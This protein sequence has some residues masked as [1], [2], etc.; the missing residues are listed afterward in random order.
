MATA[1]PIAPDVFRSAEEM[2][3]ALEKLD[4]PT[5]C[6]VDDCDN[7]AVWKVTWSSTC[8]SHPDD[9]IHT[10]CD[11]CWQHIKDTL[12]SGD[13]VACCRTCLPDRHAMYMKREERLH[14]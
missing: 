6:I 8:P 10:Y 5:P 13:I 7:E 11:E 9:M 3:E 2:F 1:T 14:A 4:F 12:A